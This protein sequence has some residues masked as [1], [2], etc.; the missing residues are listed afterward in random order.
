MKKILL[1][2]TAG[3]LLVNCNKNEDTPTPNEVVK[4]D[5]KPVSVVVKQGETVVEN[6]LTD[7]KI[8]LERGKNYI[9]EVTFSQ[10]VELQQGTF[11][12]MKAKNNKEFYANFYGRNLN[13]IEESTRFKKEG[14][15]DFVLQIVQSPIVADHYIEMT[16][17]SNWSSKSFAFPD[18]D[19]KTI[20]TI[21]RRE[22]DRT[23]VDV[24]FVAPVIIKNLLVDGTEVIK[25]EKKTEDTYRLTISNSKIASNA[26]NFFT[27]PIYKDNNGE[28]GEQVGA[29][30][31]R[32]LFQP[33]M[34]G[35]YSG[36]MDYFKYYN[37]YGWY[38]VEGVFYVHS[39]QTYV[40]V[41]N[42]NTEI[43]EKVEANIKGVGIVK[44]IFKP[45]ANTRIEGRVRIFDVYE[46]EVVGGEVVKKTNAVKREIFA[47]ISSN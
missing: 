36:I 40:F 1:F 27:L 26:E 47:E 15:N 38:P 6:A 30:T 23:V 17:I 29:L 8:T 14:Y 46:G 42:I 32:G 31:I 7:G 19:Q 21:G 22:G 45:D 34:Y 44:P 43:I 39:K 35:S 11:L 9:I 28:E 18:P 25:V 41:D 37:N 33:Y 10:D 13:T 20:W 2:F 3:L 12:K 16:P 5:L 24:M 4:Q